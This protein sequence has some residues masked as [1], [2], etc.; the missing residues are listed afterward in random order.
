MGVPSDEIG[1][2]TEVCN[3]ICKAVGLRNGSGIVC[4]V[5]VL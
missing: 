3:M 5:V 4:L 2:P 1:A